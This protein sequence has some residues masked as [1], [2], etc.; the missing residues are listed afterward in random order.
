MYYARGNEQTVIMFYT[1][2]NY[3][4]EKTMSI[5]YIHESNDVV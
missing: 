2:E 4:D 3:C 5:S 1:L